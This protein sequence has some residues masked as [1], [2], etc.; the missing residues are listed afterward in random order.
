MFRPHLTKHE[1]DGWQ[2]AVAWCDCDDPDCTGTIGV[3]PETCGRCSYCFKLN[4]RDKPERRVCSPFST[5]EGGFAGPDV[6]PSAAPPA[7]CE[8][9]S[10]LNGTH[11]IDD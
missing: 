7:S 2:L 10:L 8:I 5:E 1:A 11:E 3:V 6:D 9:R 4:S